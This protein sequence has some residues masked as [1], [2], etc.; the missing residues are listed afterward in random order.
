MTQAIK[1]SNFLLGQS[2]QY[3][4]CNPS[5]KCEGT[6]TFGTTIGSY[7]VKLVVQRDPDSDPIKATAYT[8]NQAACLSR[9]LPDAP[10]CQLK[11]VL[12]G[13]QLARPI[14]GSP[15]LHTTLKY[16]KIGA[17]S[18]ENHSILSNEEAASRFPQ[19]PP[20]STEAYSFPLMFALIAGAVFATVL[21]LI[22]RHHNTIKKQLF[23]TN[24]KINELGGR[25][26][27]QE[28]ELITQQRKYQASTVAS[29]ANKS[30]TTFE[31]SLPPSPPSLDISIMASR[32]CQADINRQIEKILLRL[33]PLEQQM[34]TI[35]VR[36]PG[37][38]DK[39][40]ESS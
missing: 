17:I 16:S 21:F 20:L 25:V 39:I 18:K 35:L 11:L 32:E 3:T 1:I 6:E 26:S 31:P 12:A 13:D 36:I 24:Q 14:S 22:K 15:Q 9:G 7:S 27:G 38:E 37:K 28:V 29:L 4:R 40:S 8:P 33:D 34:T 30:H 10:V 23:A 19:I 5:Q 2:L